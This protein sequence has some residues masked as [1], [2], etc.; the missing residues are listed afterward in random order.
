MQGYRFCKNTIA[1]RTHSAILVALSL[2]LS[3]RARAE[4]ARQH[5]AIILTND[6]YRDAPDKLP[7]HRRKDLQQW[8]RAH[9]LTFTFVGNE[10]LP[11]PQ[12]CF[13]AE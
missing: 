3:A 11:N 7:A 2:S 10:L 9:L 6:K 1:L 4:Y 12:F 5:N 13:P 8:L